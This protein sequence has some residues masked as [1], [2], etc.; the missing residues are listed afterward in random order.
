M[1]GAVRGESLIKNGDFSATIPSDEFLMPTDWT[2]E[3]HDGN[4]MSVNIGEHGTNGGNNIKLGLA[5]TPTQCS[6]E[7]EVA[8]E[9]AMGYTLT[10]DVWY[11]KEPLTKALLIVKDIA[12]QQEIVSF[13]ITGGGD[14]TT[15]PDNCHRK[16]SFISVGEKVSVSL[17]TNGIDKVLRA[18][19]FSLVKDVVNDGKTQA[20]YYVDPVNGLDTNTGLTAESPLKS[21]EGIFLENAKPGTQ[22]LFKSGTSYAGTLKFSNVIGTTD[23]PITISTYYADGESEPATIDAAGYIAAIDLM[24]CSYFT[25]SDL[26]LTANGG[27]WKLPED[28][29]KNMRCGILSR[30]S[31]T[32]QTFTDIHISDIHIDSC[33]YYNDGYSRPNNTNTA[34]GTGGYGYGI[35]VFNQSKNTTLKNVTIKNCKITNISHTGVKFTGAGESEGAWI[36]NVETTY[37]DVEFAGGPG[38][39]MGSIRDSYFGNNSVNYSGSDKDSRNWKRG[40]GL[41]TW[42]S[43][44]VLIEKNRF[45]NSSGPADSYG[46]HI[47][48]NCNNVVFQYNFYANNIGGF[49][50]ILGNCYNCSYRYNISVNDGARN[51][52]QPGRTLWLSGFCGSGARKGPYNTYIY[53]NTIYTKEDLTSRYSFEKTSVGVLVANNIFHVHGDAI[54]ASVSKAKPDGDDVFFKNNLFLKENNFPVIEMGGDDAPIYG[55]A[56]FKN[57]GGTEPEDYIPTNSELAN[58]GI[59]IPAL[60]GDELGLVIGL[61]VEY[62]ILGNPIGDNKQL[63]AVQFDT[64]SSV[65]TT[66]RDFIFRKVNNHVVIERNGSLDVKVFDAKGVCVLIKNTENFC[67]FVLERGIYFVRVNKETVKVI[68]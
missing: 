43:S 39:Q 34:N 59:E 3:F 7:Q 53:N 5:A 14:G 47:D 50:E 65:E 46:S 58:R 18:D 23:A 51:Q 68:N 10:A 19:N 11:S 42:G 24:D 54:T 55:D 13:P 33:F 17:C 56:M 57:P 49:V 40:S 48:Y 21:L 64:P 6:I 9:P 41:W 63:G 38:F 20:A 36:R 35:R 26:K 1:I 52:G 22:V 25:I 29:G 67:Q 45:T 16:V 37:T 8:V 31:M 66:E 28:K 62:D 15:L 60:P 27:G 30:T 32:S 61:D 44:D 12:T 2:V 4:V